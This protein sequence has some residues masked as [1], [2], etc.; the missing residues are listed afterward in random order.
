MWMSLSRNTVD[1]SFPFTTGASDGA[2]VG[3]E[4]GAVEGGA[5]SGVASSAAFTGRISPPM[6]LRINSDP[7]AASST[8]PARSHLTK[9]LRFI[10]VSGPP[11]LLRA[12]Y[13]SSIL[14]APET[15][16]N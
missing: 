13:D 14:L 6:S 4:L 11:W 12:K 1:N 15:S 10:G 9:L 5:A 2:G 7:D 3:V 8:M 16:G